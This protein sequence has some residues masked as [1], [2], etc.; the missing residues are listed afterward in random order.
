MITFHDKLIDIMTRQKSN[1]SKCN[2]HI[3]RASIRQLT[4]PI[5]CLAIC[6]PERDIEQLRVA[7]TQATVASILRFNPTAKKKKR[8]PKARGP[9]IQAAARISKHAWWVWVCDGA[10][11]DDRHP[12]AVVMKK[13]N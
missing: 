1:W 7:L 13:A 10:P 5:G 4:K 12:T 3:Y 2:K 9:D 8:P 6:I 11:K